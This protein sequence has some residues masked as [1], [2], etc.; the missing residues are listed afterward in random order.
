MNIGEAEV[1]PLEGMGETC[2]INT[3]LVEDCGVEVMHMDGS[4]G[5]L[6]F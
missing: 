5:E 4:R 1:A 2:V 6:F 3:Q